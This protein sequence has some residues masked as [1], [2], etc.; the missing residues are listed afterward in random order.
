MLIQATK[1]RT[2]AFAFGAVALGRL[3]TKT[4]FPKSLHF[5]MVV[6]KTAGR[7]RAGVV[8]IGKRVMWLTKL[9][10]ILLFLGCICYIMAN[11]RTPNVVFRAWNWIR[12]LWK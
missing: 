11:S 1:V 2:V 3:H 7:S 9:I 6:V 4:A 10:V 12:G 8:Y 5:L